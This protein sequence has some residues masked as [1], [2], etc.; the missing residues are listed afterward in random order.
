[1]SALR[2]LENYECEPGMLCLQRLTYDFYVAV[3]SNR[4][5]QLIQKATVE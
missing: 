2:R 4:Q 5:F 3:Q 1:M